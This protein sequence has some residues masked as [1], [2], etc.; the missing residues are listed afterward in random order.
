[1][2][3]L[4]IFDHFFHFWVFLIGIFLFFN[5]NIKI[6]TPV[7]MLSF[8]KLS[9]FVDFLYFYT[10]FDCLPFA[11][12]IFAKIMQFSLYFLTCS[13]YFFFRLFQCFYYFFLIL[14]NDSLVSLVL[15]SKLIYF[16]YLLT[17]T[18]RLK[19]LIFIQIFL[20]LNEHA[21]LIQIFSY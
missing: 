6:F 21:C 15:R 19:M 12:F 3:K 18:K 5:K 20:K 4:W 14:T 10:F 9:F 11:Y 16:T 2:R 13:K 8:V 17:S 1:M 7:D